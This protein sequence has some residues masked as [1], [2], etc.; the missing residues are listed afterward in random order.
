MRRVSSRFHDRLLVGLLAISSVA[1]GRTTHAE[2]RPPTQPA[3]AEAPLAPSAERP[4]SSPSGVAPTVEGA[5]QLPVQFPAVTIQ[6]AA[7]QHAFA[8]PEPWLTSALELGVDQQVISLYAARIEATGP[9][10]STLKSSSGAHWTVPNS[11]VVVLPATA[12]VKPGDL[13][14]THWP[15][16]GSWTRAV[17]VDGPPESPIVRFLDL[18]LDEAAGWGTREQAL[19][20]GSF[21]ELDKPGQ[22]GTTA[23]CRRSAQAPVDAEPKPA[24]QQPAPSE[25]WR[26]VLVIRSTEALVL[27][28]GFAG[29]LGSFPRADCV[30]IP[31]GKRL[32]LGALAQA[33]LGGVFVPV[34]ILGVGAPISAAA[35]RQGAAAAAAPSAALSPGS[36]SASAAPSAPAAEAP[37]TTAPGRV[38]VQISGAAAGQAASQSWQVP[39]LDLAPS[40]L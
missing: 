13:V 31:P 4:A 30:L 8:P 7:G 39:S 38:R 23:A 36:S 21:I 28:L 22:P 11:L 25:R 15:Q 9:E 32:E 10:R 2:E 18:P 5:Q 37:P 24:A 20:A 17:V 12:K 16:G 34:R 3:P 14:L 6:A 35:R 1:C 29:K 33:P 27:G 19:S 26:R 40:Q